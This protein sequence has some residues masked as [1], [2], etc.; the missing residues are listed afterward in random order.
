MPGLDRR[1]SA[2]LAADLRQDLEAAAADGLMPQA[3]IGEDVRG[4]ARRLAEEAGA[5]RIPYAYRRLLES[6]AVGALPGLV[7]GY[8]YVVP[9]AVAAADPVGRAGPGGG[10]RLLRRAGCGRGRRDPRRRVVADA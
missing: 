10:P 1:D 9:R 3:L 5:R 6:A 2:V 4:F 7:F 8:L